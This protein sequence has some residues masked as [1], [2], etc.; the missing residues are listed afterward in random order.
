M[1]N[2][3]LQTTDPLS[4]TPE[5]RLTPI[6]TTH[7]KDEAYIRLREAIV[8]LH[9][10]PGA[11]LVEANLASQLGTSKTPVRHALIRL[12][13]EGFV[14]STPSRGM[15]VHHLTVCDMRELF[16][17]R[18]ALECASARLAVERASRS[19]LAALRDT[20]TTMRTLSERGATDEM[21]P[22][23][24]QFHIQMI[25]LAHNGRISATYLDLDGQ[26]ERLRHIAGHI[27]GRLDISMEEHG[28]ILEALE[29][30]D[31]PA[32]DRAIR[33][34]LASLLT[35]YLDAVADASV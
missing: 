30:Q 4:R 27:P 2:L 3:R 35:A 14:Q 22:C 13:K 6:H 11:P 15:T 12:E 26:M 34:H 7:L 29:R 20:L 31:G 17:F 19:E 18:E 32:V 28:R 21:V 33:D 10:P 8:T 24:R 25:G 16:E 23:I 1:R 5:A 9:L